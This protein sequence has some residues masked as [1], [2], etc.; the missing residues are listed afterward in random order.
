MLHYTQ[1]QNNGPRDDDGTLLDRLG[2]KADNNAF[3]YAI[4]AIRVYVVG[5]VLVVLPVPPLKQNKIDFAIITVAAA[6]LYMS[7]AFAIK[8]ISHR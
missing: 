2:Q 6:T 3:M 4:R 8:F 5:F 1:R 7:R